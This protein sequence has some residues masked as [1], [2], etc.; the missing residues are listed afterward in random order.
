V[1][2]T[3]VGVEGVFDGLLEEGD[4][5]AGQDGGVLDVGVDRVAVEVHEHHAL[6]VHL[7]DQR[8][9][10]RQQPHDER[11]RRLA[12]VHQPS[13]QHRHEYVLRTRTPRHTRHARHEVIS[14]G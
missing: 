11:H 1:G 2:G 10:R 8:Q 12:V 3:V 5:L 13:R 4:V 7:L 14:C 6:Q 9:L